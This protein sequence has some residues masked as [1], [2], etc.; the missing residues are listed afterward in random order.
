MTDLDVVVVGAGPAGSCTARFAAAAGLRVLVLERS[1]TV[2]VPV[3]CGEFLPSVAEIKATAPTA[4]GLGELFDLPEGVRG[5]S[6]TKAKAI[7]PGG[8][9]YTVPFDGHA[10]RR[11][12]LDQHLAKKAE[13]AGA[14]VRTSTTFLGLRDD[15]VIA[16]RSSWTARVVVGADGPLS[17]VGR[18]MGFPRHA[19]LFPAMSASIAGDFEPIFRAYFGNVA[20]GG[21]AWVIPREG[22]ANV[23]LGVHPNLRREPLGVSFRR[24]L[25]TLGLDPEIRGVGGLVPMSGPLP[26]T[27]QG[28]VLLV[29]DA[30]GHVLP[31]TGG[32]IYTAMMCGRLAGLAAAD[33]ILHGK[34]LEA[35]EAHWR[36]QLGQAFEL[37]L[38]L[39]HLMSRAF[40]ADWLLEQLMRFLGPHGLARCL[41]CQPVEEGGVR[42]FLTRSM[43]KLA[44]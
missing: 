7:S 10:L 5:K 29:G 17:S 31:T 20:P 16:D 8:R 40:E 43:M 6:V 26:R 9:V 27:V 42:D 37:G 38:S 25:G 41:R 21:Y 36:E 44:R 34:P 32:G 23:G 15:E 12:I 2:G 3:R 39:F 28:N 14:E 22:D 35:Y 18:A 13:E 33:H 1:A 19:L 4:D 11:D 30:A 24:F